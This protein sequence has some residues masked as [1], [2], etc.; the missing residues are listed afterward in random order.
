MVSSLK[1]LP[2][3]LCASRPCLS[4]MVQES[5]LCLVLLPCISSS[6]TGLCGVLLLVFMHFRYCKW[7]S[8]RASNAV[9]LNSCYFSTTVR[10][11]SSD[12][13]RWAIRR[14]LR[15]CTTPSVL[16]RCSS[17]RSLLH[18]HT[19]DFISQLRCGIPRSLFHIWKMSRHMF[20]THQHL[21]TIRT[22]DR[23]IH[24]G[25]YIVAFE[26]KNEP[27]C[28]SNNSFPSV[29]CQWSVCIAYDLALLRTL[30]ASVPATVSF[31][32]HCS[33][34]LMRSSGRTSDDCSFLTFGS[35]TFCAF[36]E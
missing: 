21:S 1:W 24:W 5:T 19:T 31:V 20:T 28:V 33:V 13:L 10:R 11:S 4:S 3:F 23:T 16:T 26:T 9:D 15:A 2:V 34:A 27:S 22:T 14:T 29:G 18:R 30:C 35:D 6:S 7:R 32:F 17:V 36:A 12:Q 8:N 25:L